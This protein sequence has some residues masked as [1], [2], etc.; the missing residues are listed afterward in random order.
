MEVFVKYIED[1]KMIR[2]LSKFG[3]IKHSIVCNCNY[4]TKM[5]N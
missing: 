1:N 4:I 5:L 2:T 3:S